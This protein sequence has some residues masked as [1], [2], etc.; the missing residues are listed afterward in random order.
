M[1]KSNRILFTPRKQKDWNRNSQEIE[2]VFTFGGCVTLK[3]SKKR[4][5][6]SEVF[7]CTKTKQKYF[8]ISALKRGQYKLSSFLTLAICL[9]LSCAHLSSANTP[10]LYQHSGQKPKNIFVSILVQRKPSLSPL[11]ILLSF[12]NSI[13]N[14]MNYLTS[15]GLLEL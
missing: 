14:R 3:V 4:N 9:F 13:Y 8:C 1:I 11:L 15:C 5:G 12:R 7:I 6:L 2:N 10:S